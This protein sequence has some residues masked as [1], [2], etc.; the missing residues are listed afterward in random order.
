MSEAPDAAAAALAAA[1]PDAAAAA[2]AAAAPAKTWFDGAD[3]EL[4]GHIQTKGWHDKPANE[5]A[6]A[7]IQAHREAEKFIGVPAD[8]VVHLPK[9][10]SDEAGIAAFRTKIGVPAEAAKY[11]LGELKFSDGSEPGPEFA[12]WLKETAFKAGI[13]QAAI[14]QLAPEFIKYVEAGST[15]ESA[16]RTA[17]LADEHAALDKNWGTNKAINLAIAQRGAQ[18]LGLT[19]EEVQGLENQVGY[20][21]VMEAMRRVGELNGEAKF[22][23]QGQGPG[24]NG[25]IMT[26]E[27]A[28]ARKAELMNDQG[29]VTRYTNGDVAAN[30][31]LSDL[32][33]IIVG[34]DTEASRAA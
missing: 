14:A 33:K 5:V 4:I 26:Q 9:D 28:V 16:E 17:K 12:T 24:G 25:G 18:A 34:D 10:A 20:A 11:E 3:A 32:L 30:R 15:A 1:S 7:A 2:A 22:V 8:R 29:W 13:P 31:E 21:K 23:G 6:L 27:M 19:P